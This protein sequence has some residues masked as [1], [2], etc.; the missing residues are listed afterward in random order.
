M[1]EMVAKI[2]KA[3][4]T[5]NRRLRRWPTHDEIADTIGIDVSIVRLASESSRTPISLDQTSSTHHGY[6]TLQVLL[7]LQLTLLNIVGY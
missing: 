1:C 6:M 3:N 2:A 4:T 7:S 5:L